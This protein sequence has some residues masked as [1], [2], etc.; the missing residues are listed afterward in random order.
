M[1]IKWSEFGN[2]YEVLQGKRNPQKHPNTLNTS[3]SND[4]GTEN[5]DGNHHLVEVPRFQC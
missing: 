2:L 5:N 3:S 1:G 4:H